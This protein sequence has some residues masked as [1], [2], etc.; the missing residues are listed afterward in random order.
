MKTR[1]EI[2]KDWRSLM[3]EIGWAGWGDDISARRDALVL[4]IVLDIRDQNK[5]IIALLT[6]K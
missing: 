1:E 2:E 6:N 5:E 4:E 3:N